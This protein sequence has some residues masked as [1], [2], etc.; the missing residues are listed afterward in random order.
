M[1][2]F[3]LYSTSFAAWTLPAVR[4]A[5]RSQREISRMPPRAPAL[6]SGYFCLR[7]GFDVPAEL[8]PHGREHFLRKRVFL[9]RTEA[10]VKRCCEHFRGHGFFDRRLDSPT[11]FA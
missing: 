6:R 3:R 4:S 5:S 8:L 2:L 11:A 1:S 9:S 7:L 10:R